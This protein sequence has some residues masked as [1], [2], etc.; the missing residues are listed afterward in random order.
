MTSS[1]DQAGNL[2]RLMHQVRNCRTLAIASGKGG[3]GKSNV[4][5][6]LSIL[7]SAAGHRVA[8]VDADL[9]LANLDVLL[10]VDVRSN[11]SH[12]IA[13]TRRLEDVVVHLPCG[14]QLVPGASGLAKLSHLSEFQR[15]HLL[16]ELTLLEADND[17]IIVD[18]GAGIGPDVLHFASAADSIIVVT[19]PE[20]TAITD[21]YALVKILTQL[22]YRGTISL[23]VNF[24][25]DRQE[26]RLTY[27]RV[28]GVARQFLA[29]MVLDAGYVL[30]DPK[31]REAV[32]RREPLVLAYPTCP[33]SKCLA[34]LANRLGAGGALVDRKEG[35]FQR[36]ANWLG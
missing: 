11:L 16:R 31:V 35:F 15:A 36:V 4:A 10:D 20:P 8:L 29:A 22:S 1:D 19:A 3:V 14:V 24:A 12:V 26:A 27:Q 9:G 28:S 30:A 7:L 18:C 5:L 25:P 6:N 23:L 32:R 17:I 34:A 2:R 33:A 13:G 21:G